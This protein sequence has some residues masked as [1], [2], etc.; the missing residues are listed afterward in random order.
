MAF[1]VLQHLS[2]DF[3][4]ELA[5]LLQS[6]T[7]LS[8]QQVIDTPRVKA[9]CV[10]VIP[11][12]HMMSAIGGH[13]SLREPTHMERHALIDH[14]FRTLAESQNDRAV[15]IVLSGMGS[16][17]ANGLMHVKERGG[18][19][20]AQE[21]TSA[22]FASMPRSAI[23]TGH[24]DF[25]GSPAELARHLAELPERLRALPL[26]TA[27]DEGDQENDIINRLFVQ[28]R[29]RTGYDFSDYKRTTISRRM[30]RRMQVLRIDT[31]PEYL[32]R[33]QSDSQEAHAL[34]KDFLISVTNFFRDPDT[35]RA[36]A[37]HHL[38]EI[39]THTPHDT[40]VRV[41]VPGCATG[42]EAYSLAMLLCEAMD[43][44]SH[45]PS[46]QIFATD[47]D[48][49][50]LSTARA[51]WYPRSIA[52]DISPERLER[53]FREEAGG[54]RIT[55]ELSECLLFAHHNLLKDPPFSRLD[56]ITCRN[57]LIYFNR[58]LQ[59][60]VLGTFH[61]ALQDHGRLVLGS[62]E[63]TKA[64]GDLFKA[65]DGANR[66]YAP[67]KIASNR[68]PFTSNT[69]SLSLGE[70]KARPS[71]RQS[72]PIEGPPVDMAAVH[73][74]ALVRLLGPP[75]VLV[76]RDYEVR[77][78]EGNVGRYL[79]PVPGAP[80]HNLLQ[81]VPAE[82]RA[83]VQ[84]MLFSAF[85]EQS[86]VQSDV[87][88]SDGT[89]V[90]LT[91]SPLEPQDGR[92]QMAVIVFADLNDPTLVHDSVSSMSR[93]DEDHSLVDSLQADVARLRHRLQKTVE[94]YEISSEELRASNEEL[95]S[96]NEETRSLA[97]ELETSREEIQSTNE[98]LVTVNAELQAKVEQLARTSGDL[99][100]LM[101]ATEIGTIFLD[102]ELTL[103]RYTPLI[104]ELFHVIPSD[105]GRPFSHLSDTLE[106]HDLAKDAALV[107][108]HL[109]PIRREVKSAEGRWF[110][111]RVL[112]YRTIDDRIGGVVLT[113][114]DMTDRK[115][116]EQEQTRR[117]LQQELVTELSSFALRSD[118]IEAVLAQ[119]VHAMKQGL[120][121]PLT[122]ALRYDAHRH[123]FDLIA[124]I[125]WHE[126][127]VGSAHV[128]DGLHS[129]AGFTM[130]SKAP[131]IAND[132]RLER[133][134]E[135]PDLLLQHNVR[136]GL[137]VPVRTP[138]NISWG[139]LGAHD[140]EQHTFTALD[141][142][143][144]Q[145]LANVLGAAVGRYNSEDALRT[146]MQRFETAI[147]GS[148]VT[149]FSQDLEGR[150]TWVYNPAIRGEGIIVGSR[151]T[152]LFEREE[153]AARLDELRRLALETG[154]AQRR[155]VEV[156]INGE[157]RI[158]VM[159]T[160]LTRDRDGQPVGT[161]SAALDITDAKTTEVAL[162]ELTQKLEQRVEERTSEV[163][164]QSEQMRRL[165]S[166]L[167]LA[168]QR[169]RHRLAQIL[170]DDLQQL[171]YSLQ[172]KLSFFRRVAGDLPKLNTLVA[173]LDELLKRAIDTTRTLSVDLSPPVL[174]GE[175]L[176]DAIV[177]LALQMEELHNLKVDVSGEAPKSVGSHDLQVLLF[178]LVRELLFNIVKHAGVSEATVDLSHDNQRLTIVVSDEGAGFETDSLGI[179]PAKGGFGLYSIRERLPL[180]GGDLTI[181]SSPGN[182]TQATITLSL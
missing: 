95:Q 15:A 167:T 72:A 178:Q 57:V 110:M 125:G 64:T 11:P 159:H 107:I 153:D 23:G 19:T 67:T 101:Y 94:E 84:S 91:A 1:V 131:V 59:E 123:C 32:E 25:S 156:V 104:A 136:S 116:L 38:S 5:R 35:F 174:A 145:S 49:D 8:V 56:L 137:S 135:A 152:D 65:E 17:G 106:S 83:E 182:G 43:S 50:A 90:R 42:E 119:T 157:L 130:A 112:P 73:R 126:G 171:L 143:F 85:H 149:V 58:K 117:I 26:E 122:K 166:E 3:P 87:R 162:R 170:H 109:A 165:A 44:L 129:Q 36:L 96:M 164:A 2:P 179:P 40:P 158:Y 45:P 79:R 139:V 92:E 22:Q 30:R 114:V 169:E 70:P 82:V 120:D 13:L 52:G 39:V 29:S 62:S 18:F 146:S 108:E 10:Y 33:I 124:G 133:R 20:L 115:K 121:V 102:R 93:E 138:D 7:H 99:E 163:R 147:A 180:F 34:V 88:L 55:D 9:G 68:L 54:Y 76:T 21:P 75:S 148:P 37:E 16:D 51:G 140:D 150:Y 46:I 80:T 113:F 151:D 4:S 97:E 77:H 28:L 66:I 132:M 81:M 181:T 63:T 31:L 161:T 61:Y 53:F 118:N 173:Q 155:E 128:T 175:G 47:I 6:A 98:E 86:D 144:L 172:L 78:Y 74:Q 12:G 168:E 141:G 69:L 48:K 100:N 160:E 127:L 14:F 111:V 177:W 142:T 41:W 134:F 24:V 27:P 60:R 71:A 89:T 105:V 176:S 103:K 154:Q